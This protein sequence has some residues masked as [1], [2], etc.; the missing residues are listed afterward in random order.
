[1]NNSKHCLLGAAGK[2]FKR[3]VKLVQVKI[4]QFLFIADVI[5]AVKYSIRSVWIPFNTTHLLPDA[6]RYRHGVAAA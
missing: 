5:T 2:T 6:D 1:M 3:I 4:Y